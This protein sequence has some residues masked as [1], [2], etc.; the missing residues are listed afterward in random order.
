[1]K[2][3]LRMLDGEVGIH[4]MPAIFLRFQDSA[5]RGAVIQALVV[6][7]FR[8]FLAIILFLVMYA[9]LF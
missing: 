6:E 1:M 9:N 7:S 2:C 3:I 5:K 4:K 8:L